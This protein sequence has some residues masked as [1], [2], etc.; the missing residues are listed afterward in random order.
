MELFEQDYG[1]D[2]SPIDDTQIKQRILYFSKEEDLEFLKLCKKGIKQE[3]GPSSN[4]KGNISDF[5]LKKLR[6]L[7]GEQNN[8]KEETN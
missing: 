4:E 6:Q 5:L 1:K 2:N 3:F 7:Y 8:S